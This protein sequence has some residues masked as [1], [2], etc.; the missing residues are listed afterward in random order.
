M[1]NAEIFSQWQPART[2][3]K[4]DVII[5]KFASSPIPVLAAWNEPEQQWVYASIQVNLYQGKWNDT[6]FENQYETADAL[7]TWMP[8]P[9][10]QSKGVSHE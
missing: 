1:S 6:F 5:A 9:I 10:E 8:L 2:V 4:D 7:K 3:P